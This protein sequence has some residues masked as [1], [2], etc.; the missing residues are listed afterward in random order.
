MDNVEA[1]FAPPCSLE[2]GGGFSTNGK[3]TFHNV[4]VE[5]PHGALIPCFVSLMHVAILSKDRRGN[6]EKNNASTSLSSQ[7]PPN[8]EMEPL[9]MVND[10][11]YASPSSCQCIIIA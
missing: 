3:Y 6:D 11:R 5:L 9:M 8:C 10:G 1:F 7:K 2:E 4:L